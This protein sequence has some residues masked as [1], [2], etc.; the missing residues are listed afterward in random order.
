[1]VDSFDAVV[2]IENLS[3]ALDFALD[4]LDDGGFVVGD[5]V[6]LDGLAFLGGGF[7]GGEVADAGEAHVKGTGYG[8]GGHGDDVDIAAEPFELFF[9]G[10]AEALL[11]V[12]NE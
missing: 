12:D 5:D 2:E 6:G 1:M 3:A 8:G 4:G 7:D 11:F 10:N 9:G